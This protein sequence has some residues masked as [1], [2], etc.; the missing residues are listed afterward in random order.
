MPQE[1]YTFEATDCMLL[2][3]QKTPTANAGN[4]A[5]ICQGSTH[6]LAGTATN[7]ASVLWST[8]GTG[9]F[10]STSSLTPV[11]TPGAADIT[12]GTVTLT[13]TA[14][15]VSPCTTSVSDGK[16]LIIQ[17]TPTANAGSDATICQ[18]STHTLAG[19]ATNQ[20]NVLWSTSGTGTF[21]S[22]SSLTPVYTPGTADISAGTVTLTLTASAVSPCTASVSDGKILIIQKTPTANA[23]SD[24]TICQGSTH[25]LAGTATNQ[26]SVLWSTSGTGTFNSTSSL[27]PVYTPGASD[28]T[29]GTVTLTLTATAVSPCTASVSDG[30][31]LVI[32][33]TPTANAGS[34]A[35]ICQGSTHTLAGTATNQAN[36]L[37]STS[38][39][40]TFSSTSSLTPVYT[41]GAADITAGT[42]T[43]T[44]TAM[45]VSPCTAS[46]SDGKILIIQKTPT[47]NA[48]SDATICQG[49]THTLAGTAT[50]Q[51]SVLWSTSGT[52]TF[53]STSSLTPVYTPGAADITAGTVTLT[54]TAS[55]VSPCTASV[56]DGKIL[57]IQKTPTANAGSDATICQGST[58]TLAGTATNQASVLWSTSGTGTFSSTSSLT[59]VYTPGAADITA[60]TVTLTLT[61]SAVS[62]CTA[63][64]SDG[65]ILIIQKTPTANAGSDATI[66]E[67]VSFPVSA[68][69]ANYSSILWQTNGDGTFSNPALLNSV[70][71]PGVLDID[72]S[73]VIL[74]IDVSSVNPC[75]GQVNDVLTLTIMRQQLIQIPA[76]WSGISSFVLPLNPA[77]DQVMAPVANNLIIAKNMVQVYWPEFVINTIGTFD[78]AKGYLVKMNAAATLP[79]SGFEFGNK[80]INLTAGWNILPVLSPVNIGYQQL[81]TQLGN[82]LIIVTEI[83]GTGIIWP[84]EGI[85]TIPFLVPGKAYM[86]KLTSPGSFTFPD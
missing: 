23:G 10:S 40:G 82:N 54:L 78:P 16:I 53:S 25:T 52:G 26:A 20:A 43:L 14:L 3:I 34:D 44:L 39:T 68:T 30:K 66:L 7:Q 56:S 9:T 86:I 31:I 21:S 48:G 50:N 19:T 65:K 12:A 85:Y 62:P 81:I 49:S 32:Q 74:T 67:G 35:T 27:T 76:G 69:A 11:Y 63:S 51:A 83:A 46:V 4:D 57:I 75:V 17:K 77:F 38:G 15:A 84:D 8:S 72:N 42:V 6:T 45:A 22:T 59:P 60:G 58:H 70:Y 64:V 80:T 29:A 28:I 37:W 61:A 47:V 24:A 33:K 18:G 73:T 36:V 79:I 1:P 71:Y 13:I 5:T 41:P 2:T 55:A